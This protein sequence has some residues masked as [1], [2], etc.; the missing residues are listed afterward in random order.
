MLSWIA[1]FRGCSSPRSQQGGELPLVAV[2]PKITGVA[3]SLIQSTKISTPVN[4]HFFYDEHPLSSRCLRRMAKPLLMPRGSKKWCDILPEDG[5]TGSSLLGRISDTVSEM[6]IETT[7]RVE[8]SSRRRFLQSAAALGAG[9]LA[10]NAGTL[11][12]ATNKNSKLRIF[13]IGVNGIGNLQRKG[14]QGHP[15]VEFAGFCDVDKTAYEKVEKDYGSAWRVTDYREAFANR[16]DQFDAVIVDTPDFHHCPM[17]TTALKHGKHVYGQKPLVHQLDE[18]RL[19]REALAANPGL[20]TQMGNQRACLTGRMQAVELLKSNRLG[21]PVEAHIW[22]S[23]MSR[24]TYF[25]DPWSPLTA[26]Q[27]VPET[28]TWDLWNGP[29]TEALPYS[30]DLHPRR[31]R[32]YWPT[33]GGMLADWGCHLIDLLYFAYDLPSPESVQTDTM[34]PSDICHSGYNHATLTYPGGDRFAGDKFVMHYCDSNIRPSFAALGLPVSKITS[35]CTMVVC[36]EGALLLQPGGEMEIYRKG[37]LVENEPLPEVAP[38]DHW[39]DWADCCLGTE[40]P[41]WTQFDIGSRIT[42]PALLATKATRY[43][44][45]EL[46]WD[47]GNYRFTNHEEA[48]AQILSR[49]Y[50]EGFAP[51]NVG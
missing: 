27:P 48:N 6:N 15:M 7:P 41:L 24:G 4:G 33:G 10:S 13:Q 25:V 31:W 30:E 43:P 42:E 51:P 35:T 12:A 37:K 39:K 2:S 40:K 9:V 49:T 22:T 5:I 19:I 21:R 36:E 8:S 26:A 17:M 20:Y 44:G 50:R 18:L 34:K 28:M 45:Q 16:V 47:G 23:G 11:R 46:H 32:S 1:T 14:L 38:R 29:L 3:L